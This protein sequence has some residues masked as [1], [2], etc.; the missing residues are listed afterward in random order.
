MEPSSN[1]SK[2]K[3][4]FRARFGKFLILWRELKR[5]PQAF[6][7]L[8]ACTLAMVTAGL[9]PAYL[10]LSTPEIQNQLRNPDSQ[11]P[12]YIGFAFLLLAV[13]TLVAGTSGDLFGRKLILLNGLIG[14]TLANLFGAVS[15][16]TPQFIITD[17]IGTITAAAIM[18]MCVALVTFAY[19]LTTRPLAFGF[20]YGLGSVALIT[21]ASIGGLCDM[22]GIPSAAFIPVV[23]VGILSI[24][25]VTRNVSESRAGKGFR[26]ASAVVNLL[27]LVGIFIFI[28]LALVAPKSLIGW[29]PVLLAG[30]SLLILVICVRWLRN[31][32]NFFHGVEMFTGTDTG[33]SIFAGLVLFMGQGALFYQL[34]AFF[35]KVQGM[36]VVQ[37][38]I[39][40]APFVL[41]IL[42]GTAAIPLLTMRM[43]ARRIIVIGMLG[44]GISLLWLSFVWVDTP[45]WFV[46]TPLI[47]GGIGFGIASPARTQVVLAAP[48]SELTGSAAAVNTA[49]GQSGYAL[50]VILSSIIITFMANTALLEPLT[51]MGVSEET[52]QQVQS[53]LPSILNQT[54]S[55]EYPNVPQAV[56]DLI[57]ARYEQLLTGSMGQMFLIMAITLF[58]AVVIIYIGMRRGLRIGGSS[59]R[60]LNAPVDEK[61]MSG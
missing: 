44:L 2:K 42:I 30:C 27:L 50:G 36:S 43:G 33:L 45:F 39:A 23:I 52:I 35:Q 22:W 61:L 59:L 19:P 49:V 14:L 32:V 48:P 54:A 58:L 7:T 29:L 38:G 21:G 60:D 31:R 20:M 10:T 18:P 15:F 37:A 40:L 5:D 46:L 9:E 41:G 16:G 25:L 12:L 24:R 47:L 3:V 53:A 8:I 26:R 4:S 56:F 55:S 11:A 34:T 1:T 17:I 13:L 57:Y 6:R 51:Q 28:F